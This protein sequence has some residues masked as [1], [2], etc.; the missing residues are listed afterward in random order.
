VIE[1]LVFTDPWP[2]SFFLGELS[3]RLVYARVAER[4]GTL[5]GYS[6]AWLGDAAA[7]TSANLAVVPEQRRRGVARVL[8][9]DLFAEAD[10]RR[11][12]SLTLEVRVSNF[13][14]QGLYRAHGFRLAGL[15]RGYYR[16]SGE[17]ALVMEWRRPEAR[18]HVLAEARASRNQ[19][20]R[21]ATSRSSRRAVD[22]VRG[23]RRGAVPERAGRK[24][25]DVP[26]L[27]S[28]LP[29][30]GPHLPPDPDRP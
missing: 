21:R 11:V 24:P 18:D 25:V 3:Q 7:A 4:E 30:S 2:A 29:R 8:L 6:V 17:D 23:L 1:G 19:V 26:A 22:Q 5:A 27:Q 20:R 15:R 13:A 10:R 9:E 14:A 28:S 12:E 16:D